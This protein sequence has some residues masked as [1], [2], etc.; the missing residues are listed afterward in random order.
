MNTTNLRHRFV[1]P[2]PVGTLIDYCGHQA[3]VTSDDGG[4]RINVKC[5]GAAQRWYW[6]FEGVECSVVSVPEAEVPS[7]TGDWG[8]LVTPEEDARL[9]HQMKHGP[10]FECGAT[11]PEDANGK[12]KCA[13]DRDHCHG[14]DLWPDT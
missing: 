2:L 11:T 13:G 3:E 5:E 12:C 1:R 4:E 6:S 10:C 7:V 8:P 14:C 9:T